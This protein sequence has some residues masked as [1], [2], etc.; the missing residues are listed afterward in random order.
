MKSNVIRMLVDMGYKRVK[1]LPIFIHKSDPT[2]IVVNKNSVGLLLINNLKTFVE[3]SGYRF[4]KYKNRSI[5]FHRLYALAFVPYMD[6]FPKGIKFNDP[7]LSKFVPNHKDGNKLNNSYDNLEWS[8]YLENLE[9]AFKNGLRTDN[10]PCVMYDVIEDKKMEFYSISEFSRYIGL[11]QDYSAKYLK[12]PRDYLLRHR[13]MLRLKDEKDYPH[14]LSKKD[15]WKAGR[16]SIIPIYLY[17]NETGTKEI[18]YN[19]SLV[20]DKIGVSSFGK[21]KLSPDMLY[22]FV[23]G[24]YTVKV[25]TEYEDIIKALDMHKENFLKRRKYTEESKRKP[26]KVKMVFG[27]IVKVYD[28]ISEAAKDNDLSPTYLKRA[29]YLFKGKYKG[30]IF[31]YIPRSGQGESPEP[32][33]S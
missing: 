31:S 33:T 32:V 22:K 26:K 14:K 27:S 7:R 6:K 3:D 17:D 25:I 15:V 16:G 24:K 30:R 13:Y 21:K 12:G 5:P 8:T 29:I 2:P 11:H 9:H 20:R 10:K 19:S 28:S 1:G 4:V 18:H 23:D